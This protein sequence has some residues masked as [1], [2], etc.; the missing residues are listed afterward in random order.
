MNTQDILIAA[1]SIRDAVNK[2][3]VRGAQNAGY[4]VLIHNKCCELIE[5]ATREE[6]T[7]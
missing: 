7:E 5:A 4:V 1:A 6:A 2:L 3:E